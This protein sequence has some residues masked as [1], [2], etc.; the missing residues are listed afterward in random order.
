MRMKYQRD[1][2]DYLMMYPRALKWIDQCV[3]CQ[4]KGYKPE[5]PRHEWPNLARYYQPLAVGPVALCADCAA[6]RSN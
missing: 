4:R 3:V 6:N 2:D 5:M 1:T